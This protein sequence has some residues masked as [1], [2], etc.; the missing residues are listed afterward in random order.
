MVPRILRPFLTVNRE[1]QTV[2]VVPFKYPW[3][4]PEGYVSFVTLSL[5]SKVYETQKQY[6]IRRDAENQAGRSYSCVTTSRTCAVQRVAEFYFRT[7]INTHL[8]C[9]EPSSAGGQ[10]RL[11]SI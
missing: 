9:Y 6:A 3:R 1:T 10:R 2:R 4:T 7:R 8:M 11:S 5:Q